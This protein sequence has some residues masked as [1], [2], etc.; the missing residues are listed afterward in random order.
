M[1]MTTQ[2]KLV[3]GT[4]EI[5]IPGRVSLDEW[6]LFINVLKSKYSENAELE[7]SLE[8]IDY[9]YSELKSNIFF[10]RFE[11]DA[12]LDARLLKEQKA[13]LRKLP[14][15]EREAYKRKM[16]EEQIE[17]EERAT[18]ARL[19]EKFEQKLEDS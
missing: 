6:G 18:Y 17:R 2:K 5:E 9:D 10:E 3:I 1:T 12:E 13:L 11:T 7:I 4:E 15:A 16:R 19:K 14:K 8:W